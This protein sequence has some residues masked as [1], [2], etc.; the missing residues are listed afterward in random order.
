MDLKKE[1][2]KGELL[3]ADGRIDEAKAVFEAILKDHPLNYEV[4][5]NL[6][7]IYYNSGD[8]QKAETYFLSTLAVKEDYLDALVNLAN[9]YQDTKCWEEAAVQ[10]E[11]H[12]VI[13]GQDPNLFNQLGIVYLEMGNTE[14]ARAVLSKSL[15][16]NP[17]QE[18]IQSMVR[19]LEENKPGSKVRNTE[20]NQNKIIITEKPH[21]I[22]GCL[23]ERSDDVYLK[24]V[25]LEKRHLKTGMNICIIS[26]LNIAGLL[27]GLMRGINKYS[28]HKARCIIWHND[29]FYYDKDI[30]LDECNNDFDEACEIVNKA[31]FFHFGRFVFNFPGIDFNKI[32]NPR[33]CVI[34]Y[35]GSFL[36]LYP[37]VCNEW[38]RKT[39]IAAI[40]GHA[41]K[42]TWLLD[43]SFHHIDN[44]IT[45][46]GD[47]DEEDIP[48]AEEPNGMIRIVAGSAGSPNK[49]YDLFQKA[50]KELQGQGLPVEIEI[51]KGVSNEESLRRK[52]KCHIT[53]TSLTGGWGLSGIESM[54][55]GHPVMSCI[56]PFDLSLYPDQPTVIIDQDN[57]VEQIKRLVLS[58]EK[59]TGIGK[60]S[61]E[62]VKKHFRT[63]DIVKKYLYVFDLIIN[64]DKYMEG[65]LRA[66]KIYKF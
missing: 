46:Y 56:D 9:L 45:K 38:H 14:K 10:L 1:M 29:H 34:S 58:P 36:R 51:I 48:L 42:I 28:E 26:D 39:G 18:Q 7:V 22:N 62:F 23:P 13:N 2:E 8:I 64:H 57:L 16:L 53:F 21:E 31:D 24:Q 61:R 30:I 49:R 47:M 50:V 4:L 44:Y 19:S 12:I 52:Q 27:T 32:L 20:N 60:R 41:Y 63:K 54:W 25:P 6:G 33:N 11:K 66:R 55:L 5:N 40:S 15:E 35:Y 17:D 43:K 65:G 37:K 3:F 59:I